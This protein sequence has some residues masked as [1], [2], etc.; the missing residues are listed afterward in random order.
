M[1][2]G[3]KSL[4]GRWLSEAD[5]LGPA[6]V[7]RRSESAEFERKI[8][9]LKLEILE[10]GA[11]PVLAYG[12]YSGYFVSCWAWQHPAARWLPRQDSKDNSAE[13]SGWKIEALLKERDD[14]AKSGRATS[15]S[16]AAVAARAAE[17]S[18]GDN[19]FAALAAFKGRQ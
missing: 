16:A 6:E 13:I 14:A 9:A 15:K 7:L 12:D 17:F 11:C 4:G 8:E 3:Y 5:L 1:S 10:D 18:A 2:I 19:R